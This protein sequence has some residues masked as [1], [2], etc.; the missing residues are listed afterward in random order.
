VV[1]VSVVA[2]EEEG[3][4][5]GAVAYVAKPIDEAKLLL[6]V[7]RGL[8]QRGLVLVVADVT[9]ALSLLREA[10]I[11]HG[12]SVRT[13]RWGRRAIRLAKEIHPALI[14]LDLKLDDIDGYE[15]LR[16]LK[17]HPATQDIPIVVVTGSVTPEELEQTGV[18]ELG[19]AQFLRKPFSVEELIREITTVAGQ[20]VR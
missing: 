8:D 3:L 17:L 18:R 4:R 7:R 9:D 16:A 5:M 11:R 13:T 14:L 6:A 12:Y 1:I 15:V 10:L 2:S 19:A 20:P